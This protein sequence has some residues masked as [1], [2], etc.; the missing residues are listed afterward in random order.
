[1]QASPLEST[2]IFGIEDPLLLKSDTEETQRLEPGDL[3]VLSNGG[4]RIA[5]IAPG[6]L[7]ALSAVFFATISD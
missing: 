1:V 4:A 5:K 6:N 2:L 3:A 7:S